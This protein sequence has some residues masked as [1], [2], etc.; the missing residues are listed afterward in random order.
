MIGAPCPDRGQIVQPHVVLRPGMQGDALMVRDLQD[1]VKRVIAP[2][3][4]PR[5]IVFTEAL[6]KTESGKIQR[7]RLKQQV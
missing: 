1:H 3:K 4:Y 2:Y 5:S 7:F 6:P